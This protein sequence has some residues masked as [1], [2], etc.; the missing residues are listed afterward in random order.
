M[1][2]LLYYGMWSTM[3]AYPL[4]FNICLQHCCVNS[5]RYRSPLTWLTSY[6]V[7]FCKLI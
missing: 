3:L 6:I 7:Y 4:Y 5:I 1:K 2:K